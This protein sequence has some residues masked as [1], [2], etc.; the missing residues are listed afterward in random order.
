MELNCNKSTVPVRAINN[1][2]KIKL[3]IY[4]IEKYSRKRIRQGSCFH[5][6]GSN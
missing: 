1:V 6:Q 5:S 4:I 3:K 2:L